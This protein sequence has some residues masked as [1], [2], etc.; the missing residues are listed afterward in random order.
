MCFKQRSDPQTHGVPVLRHGG[1]QHPGICLTRGNWGAKLG[2]AELPLG[3]KMSNPDFL[4]F[5]L[6]LCPHLGIS[7][8]QFSKENGAVAH[9]FIQVSHGL[10]GCYVC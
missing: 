7:V 3:E 1:K 8:S 6:S 9:G 5:S 2:E 4:F 10:R